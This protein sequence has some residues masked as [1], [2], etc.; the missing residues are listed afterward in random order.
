MDRLLV[1]PWKEN[2]AVVAATRGNG[3]WLVPLEAIIAALEDEGTGDSDTPIAGAIQLP[4]SAAQPV[5]RLLFDQS[6][7]TL[8]AGVGTSLL[9]WSL[10]QGELDPSLDLKLGCQVA[11][12]TIDRAPPDAEG[13]EGDHLYIATNRFLL[14]RFP[15][16]E[17][18]LFPVSESRLNGREGAVWEGRVSVVEHLHPLSD[19]ADS[20]GRR[21]FRHR[22]VVG[23]SLRHAFVIFDDEHRSGRTAAFSVRLAVS[24][25]KI[26]AV[27]PLVVPQ[28]GQGT[29]YGLAVSTL[30]QRIRI[31]RPSG[32]RAPEEDDDRPFAR[33]VPEASSP[34]SLLSGYEDLT[35]L[36]DRVYGMEVLAEDGQELAVLFG[37]GNHTV[38]LSRLRVRW[39]LRKIARELAERLVEE[40]GALEGVLEELQAKALDS[41]TTDRERRALIQLIPP[42]GKRCHDEPRW[43]QFCFFVWDVLGASRSRGRIP[44]QMI[45]ALR[46]L[47]RLRPDR[48]QGLE[49]IISRV[50]KYVLDE[51]SFSSKETDFTKLA[52]STDPG[53]DDDRII[54]R[55][56]LASR[57]VDP[58]F[59]RHVRQLGEVTS[60]A[61]L[62]PAGAS[63]ENLWTRPPRE[64]TFLVG[65][66]RRA[67][68][69]MSGDGEVRKLDI[70]EPLGSVRAFVLVGDH[71]YFA[72]TS[73]VLRRTER[74]RLL[75]PPD[76][77]GAEL[78]LEAVPGIADE[79]LCFISAVAAE[80]PAGT[81]AS[82]D[83][84]RVL[85]GDRAGRIHRVGGGDL[86]TLF[87]PTEEST[88]RHASGEITQLQA[89][90][91]RSPEGP[92]R[93]SLLAATS[94]ELLL[95]D[96]RIR[97]SGGSELKEVDRVA[98]GP[99]PITALLV[100][101]PDRRHVVVGSGDGMI[102][103]LRIVS[104]EGEGGG[105]SPR[106]RV[107]WAF[108]TGAAV[109]AIRP[110]DPAQAEACEGPLHDLVLAGS[111]DEHLHA[112]DLDGRLLE[113]FYLPGF[114]V[115]LFETAPRHPK[116]P[117]HEVESRVY[118]CAFENRLLG[119]RL[120]SRRR[121]LQSL[122][123]D[124]KRLDGVERERRLSRWRT[125]SIRE[126]HLRHR[127]IRQSVRY[128]GR[129][130]ADSLRALERLVETED[131]SDLPTGE[132]TALIRRLF[133]NRFP[134]DEEEGLGGAPQG[135][136]G[137]LADADL[138]K[139]TLELLERLEERWDAPG[140]IA[141]RRVQLFWIRS[142]LRNLETPAMLERWLDMKA[143][144]GPQVS[145]AEP[146]ALLRHFL[147]HAS[148]LLQFKTLQYL[149]RL[150]FGWPGVDNPLGLLAQEPREG[151]G[152]S[153]PIG[154]LFEGLLG[155][156]RFSQS[157]GPPGE[158]DSVVLQCGRIFCRLVASRGRRHMDPLLLAYRLQQEELPV[159]L[160]R[161][162]ADQMEILVRDEDDASLAKVL[163]QAALLTEAV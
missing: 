96:L 88:T 97:P 98:L 85:L 94:G 44:V 62:P 126:G 9:A 135:L 156:L 140:S 27:R 129:S 138:F 49:A 51:M 125:Y 65:T 150:L 137:I 20:Y 91:Y 131:S 124:L 48:G 70:P 23:A 60:F 12:L 146:G 162:F 89:F 144:L 120:V 17:S 79:P 42:V 54:Y 50:R 73:G 139:R 130:V 148:E 99:S 11:A 41:A 7:G 37:L 161:Q 32:V 133:Q 47:Q 14:H 117:Q 43:R 75:A 95:F 77:E 92:S 29:W 24:L 81:A 119:L 142:F 86:A 8:F 13:S 136:R 101:G 2:H 112:L 116:D 59:D 26:L 46:T 159:S 68:W 105:A 109:R 152:R 33:D 64:L 15:R 134:W 66:L 111:H 40:A 155:C 18:G 30:D 57:R 19:L 53:L 74:G 78:E 80:R 52:S 10:R 6:T 76:R 113:T 16:D 115:D 107:V 151:G 31:F 61:L 22:G 128:P 157:S 45:Q 153:I 108:R 123:E 72:F 36:L 4:G 141:N 84:A 25:S 58:L 38:R 82:P 103:G 90:G 154:W 39:D 143:E 114:K 149:E 132:A 93:S 5:H 87:D 110:L 71:V 147:E 56:I 67:V 127:F 160:L 145:L 28:E 34:T 69:L 83:G 102:T 163:R 122:Q 106:L 35:T 63:R 55:S 3:A 118:G 121:L 158:A 100:T 21:L 1:V 104:L